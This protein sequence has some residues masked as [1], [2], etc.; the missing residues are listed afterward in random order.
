[1]SGSIILTV[2]LFGAF[3][4]YS[5]D[6][7]LVLEVAQGVSCAEVK[8]YLKVALKKTWPE[9]DKQALVDESALADEMQVLSEDAKIDRNTALAIL[10]PVCGG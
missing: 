10:P 9:F 8:N 3:R 2:K 5:K 4:P 7:P 6:G 1:M